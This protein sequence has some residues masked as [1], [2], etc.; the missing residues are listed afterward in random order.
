MGAW[1]TRTFECD[2]A[3]D[4]FSDFCESQENVAALEAAFDAVLQNEDY[5]DADVATDALASA[6]IIAYV[7]G[8]PSEDFPSEELHQPFLPVE[9]LTHYLNDAL[10]YKAIKAVKKVKEAPYS[11]LRELW[12]EADEY[13]AEWQAVMD[14]LMQRVGR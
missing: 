8:H 6:E 2:S 13:Y 7:K 14:D 3:L 4:F 9:S 11:E 12:E 5:I 10:V 1:G